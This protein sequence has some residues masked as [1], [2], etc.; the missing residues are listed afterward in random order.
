MAQ[1]FGRFWLH[2]KIGHGGMAEIFRASM[3]ADPTNY[4]FELAVKRLQPRY[5]DDGSL[6]SAFLSEAEVTK[7][8][9]HQN[10]VHSS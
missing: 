6:Q 8:L 3:G 10:I 7:Y 2:E 9:K 4:D 5:K 1:Q